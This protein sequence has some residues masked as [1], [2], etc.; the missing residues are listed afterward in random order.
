LLI[1]SRVVNA[2]TPEEAQDSI[3]LGRLFKQSILKVPEFLQL[4]WPVTIL[5]RQTLFQLLNY[6][7]GVP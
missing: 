1:Q 5:R 7:A 4:L 6:F 2:A 3:P